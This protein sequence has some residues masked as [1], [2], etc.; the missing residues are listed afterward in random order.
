MDL[1][2]LIKTNAEKAAEKFIEIANSSEYPSF[3]NLIEIGTKIA[4]RVSDHIKGRVLGTLGNL[5]YA[6]GDFEKAEKTYLDTL[7]LYIDLAKENEEYMKYVAGA[8]FNLGNLYQAKRKYDE[9]EKA[10][11][12][13]INVLNFVKDEGMLSNVL[14]ALGT[15][16]ARTGQ[17]DKAEKI[18]IKAFEVKKKTAKSIEDARELGKILNN[19]A[20]VLIRNNRKK[21]AEILLNKALE[22]F[23]KLDAYE[24]LASV[25]Q[26][27]YSLL[28]S[29][30]ILN[31]L[32]MLEKKL[33]PDLRAKIWYVK[34]KKLEKLGKTEDSAKNYVKAACYA[35]LAYRKYG[36]S[37]VNFIHCLEKA[38]DLGVDFARVLR[39]AILRVYFNV[40]IE[41]FE[42]VI[43]KLKGLDGEPIKDVV[44]TVLKDLG[45]LKS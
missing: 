20:V 38:E 35:F 33:L 24:E 14:T 45:H 4:E 23:E 43:G 31:K 28:D 29:D 36:I 13:A 21:E 18:L 17:D 44:E 27:L 10:Y 6:M 15:M 12:D 25:L 2:E 5:Y 30:E 37:S 16:Y 40:N 34:A 32:E 42:E 26:N 3:Q 1:E 11:N 7:N 22:T 41:N 39:S 8:L 19:L 9:A